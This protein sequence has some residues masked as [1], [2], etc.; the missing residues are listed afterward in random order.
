MSLTAI[1]TAHALLLLRNWLWQR[2][3][4]P[5]GPSGLPIVGNLL[6]LGPRP[7][8]SLAALANA[9]GPLLSLKLGSITTIVASS[10]KI[11]K[12]ILQKNDHAFAGRGIPDSA[13]AEPNYELSVAWLPPGP[14]WRT[15]R[16]ILNTQ[17]MTTQM[18]DALQGLRNEKMVE[19][20]RHLGEVA[21][22]GKEV[23]IGWLAFATTFNLL[24]TAVFSTNLFDLGP[25]DGSQDFKDA[26]ARI[27]EL[28]GRPN[29][30]DYF[31][32]L[33][34]FDLQRL[35]RSIK[36]HYDRLHVLINKMIDQRL[37]SREIGMPKK[38]D[39][40]EVLLDYSQE[41]GPEFDRRQVNSL[42][43]VRAVASALQTRT[44]RLCR[45]FVFFEMM[46]VG[47]PRLSFLSADDASGFPPKS[48]SIHAVLDPI[49]ILGSD[50]QRDLFVAGSD[51]TS[52]TIEWVMAELLRNPEAMAKAKQEL[53][54]AMG[55]S[56]GQPIQ[57]SDIPHL[58]YLQ[59]VVK[60]AMR[61]HPTVPLL[62]PHKTIADVE[63]CGFTIPQ[64]TQVLI[65]AWA[66][67]RDSSVWEDPTSFKPERFLTSEVD[68]R[69]GNFS[70]IPF[71]AGR[72][73]CP[74]MP[75]AVRMVS[76]MVATLVHSFE[77]KLP[78]GMLAHEM[79]MGD[80]FGVTLQKADP[81][82]AI[83]F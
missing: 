52:T 28:A 70:F 14:L 67:A 54:D 65:N 51:T 15:L 82:L 56:A 74:G 16:K 43:A 20:V 5:P 9:Y 29:L 40:L 42:V 76:L 59:A 71:G 21:A 8:E 24:S 55:T 78:N 6:Q 7:H 57:E 17:I 26:T 31:P 49:I 33:R 25:E 34:P 3:K 80:R 79:D 44:M 10:P 75:L 68:F 81:L 23:N 27:M 77:W 32:V 66:L 19:M 61:L 69:D 48:N 60:E 63:L 41:H 35:R 22:Q 73:I 11:A 64:N 2:T 53:A 39:F 1:A 46:Q 18:L 4:L 47:S 13:T 45:E 30:S 83:P 37:R 36:V 50:D 72:R 58:R 38:N 62:L 12:E